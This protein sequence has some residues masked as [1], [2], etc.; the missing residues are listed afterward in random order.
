MTVRLQTVHVAPNTACG[1]CKKEINSE[2]WGHYQTALKV[3]AF[4]P[5]C[6]EKSLKNGCPTCKKKFTNATEFVFQKASAPL[7]EFF[8]IQGAVLVCIVAAKQISSLASAFGAD[9]ESVATFNSFALLS[10]LSAGAISLTALV[11]R[12]N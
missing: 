10:A 7:R 8:F 12:R 5:A 3:D 4:H 1:I 9:D 6:I 2:A 11:L